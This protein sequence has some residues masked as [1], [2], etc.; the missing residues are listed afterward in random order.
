MSLKKLLIANRGEIAVRVARGAAELGIGTVAVSG[1]DDAASLHNRVADETVTLEGRGAA[2]YLDVGQVVGAAVAAGCDAIHPGYGFLA[3]N[4]ALAEACDAAGVVFVGPTADQLALFGDKLAARA[5]A[6]QHGVPLVSAT[7]GATSLEEAAAFFVEN[8][9]MMIK[10][11]AGGGGRGMR[12]VR[13]AGELEAAYERCISEATAAFGLGDVYVERL[14]E[15]ARHI[16]VQI[17]G[18]G[19]EVS[20]LGERECT[21]QRQNQKIVEIA[22]SPSLTAVTRQRIC[23]AA[24]AMAADRRYRSLG[25][26]EF[27]VDADDPATVAFIEVNARIQVEHTVTEEVTGVDLVAAPVERRWP[28]WA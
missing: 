20:H 5:L 21:L 9:P 28:M 23:D 4:S 2:P 18:D 14:I 15:R 8:G 16:E 26:W 3:E 24:I 6:E 10:A 13:T 17:I 1:P 12:L 7:N 22:P 11:V 27:L 25:T 19:T